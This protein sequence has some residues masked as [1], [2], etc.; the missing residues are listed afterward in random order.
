MSRFMAKRPIHGRRVA[1]S[2]LLLLGMDFQFYY[3][4]NTFTIRAILLL[5]QKEKWSEK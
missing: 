3:M 4:I 1:D 5:K 2:E